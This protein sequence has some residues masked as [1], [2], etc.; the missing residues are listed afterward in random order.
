MP[1]EQKA[2]Y[3]RLQ[4]RMFVFETAHISRKMQNP[5]DNTPDN[6]LL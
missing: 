5:F 2:T 6:Y 1:L 4:Y 3:I